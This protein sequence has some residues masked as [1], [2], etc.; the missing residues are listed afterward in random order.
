MKNKFVQSIEA[1]A[2]SSNL[3]I[4]QVALALKEA[5]SKAFIKFLDGG[6]DALI[7]VDIDLKAG[8]IG[9]FQQKKV[10][11]DVQDD[12]LEISLADAQKINPNFK[13]DDIYETSYSIDDFNKGAVKTMANVFKQ[14]LS[15]LQKAALYEQYKDKIGE[16]ITGIVES[17][18]D[19]GTTLKVGASSYLFLNSK[20][21]IGDETFEVGKPLK[22][23]VVSV[24]STTKGAQISISRSHEGFLRRLMEEEIH[25]I[26]D[27]T[28]IIKA[29]A[30]EAGERSKVAVISLD[31]NV[32]PTGA[33]I[34]PNGSRIQKVVAQLGNGSQ[35]EKIDIIGYNENPGL[36][37]IEALRPAQ[38]IGV[39]MD[40]AEHKATAVVNN[41]GLSVAIGKKG[42]N[43][44]LAV[45]LTNWHIDIKEMDEALKLG[46]KIQ[47]AEE[48]S[49]IQ[50]EKERVKA[51]EEYL[52]SIEPTIKDEIPSDFVAPTTEELPVDEVVDEALTEAEQIEETAQEVAA[53]PVVESGE[54]PVAVEPEVAV[55]G[56][57]SEPNVHVKTTKTLDELEAELENEKQRGKQSFNRKKYR[58]P[59]LKTDEKSDSPLPQTAAAPRMD[60][61][62]DEE[63][64]Q[65]EAEE[66]KDDN[67]SDYDDYDDLYDEELVDK[68]VK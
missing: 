12:F 62:T 1:V 39:A 58:K 49:A 37:I 18:D 14:K 20:S 34:G 36:F 48:L 47:T 19:H 64:A 44:R 67:N 41:G 25:E 61:Y 56:V 63:L 50:K 35:T 68:Y 23:Y 17:T 13:V 5:V 46:L 31:P 21:A 42:V 54:I 55:A 15:D 24:E 9:L 10:V 22:V 43:V 2:A 60:I 26:Y 38:V 52:A 3:D 27:G 8:E 32:D 66:N 28:V 45:K 53:S 57:V 59:D 65:L 33:C 40:E 51:Q 6:D 4:D 30:R 29:I 11:E 16:M 7:R